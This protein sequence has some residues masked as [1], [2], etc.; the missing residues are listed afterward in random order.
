MTPFGI[1]SERDIGP[2]DGEYVVDSVKLANEQAPEGYSFYFD[3]P[4][5]PDRIIG[6]RYCIGMFGW[7]VPRP[8]AS[9]F[10]RIW[11][12]RDDDNLESYDYCHVS[13]DETNGKPVARFS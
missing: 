8:E 13:F 5:M 2:I 1:R 6:G 11:K 12:R 3:E 7:L 4:D 9:E 10:E